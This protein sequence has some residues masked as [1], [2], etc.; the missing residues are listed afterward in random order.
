MKKLLLIVAL[1]FPLAALAQWTTHGFTIPSAHP[2]LWWNSARISAAQT[3]FASNP[4]TPGAC[5]TSGAATNCFN[6]A[7]QHVVAGDDCSSAVSWATTYVPL[8]TSPS[9][10]GSNDM[11]WYGETA[12]LV[13]DWCNDQ[14]TSGQKTTFITKWNTYVGNTD[15]QTWGGPTSVMSNYNWGNMRNDLEWGVASY[16][17]NG[18]GPGSTADNFIDSAITSRWGNITAA[19]SSELG[20]GIPVEG[21]EYGEAMTY[22]DIPFQTLELN[23]RDIFN[24]TGFFKQ[25]GYWLDY[26]T[27]PAPT[28]NNSL[29]ATNWQIIPFGDDEEYSRGGM[30]HVT[31]SYQSFQNLASN[32]WSSIGMGKNS[33]EWYNT[34]TGYDVLSPYNFTLAQDASPSASSFSSLPLDYYA[35]GAA[36]FYGKDSWSGSGTWFLWQLSCH[37]DL[38][39]GGAHVHQDYDTF[40]IWQ[41]GRWLSRESAGYADDDTYTGYNGTGT[42]SARDNIAHNGVLVNPAS[43]GCA[44]GSTCYGNGGASYVTTTLSC[45]TVR[46]LESQASYTYADTDT[47]NAEIGQHYNSQYGNPAVGYYGGPTGHMEREIIFVRP[48][49]TTVILDRLLSVSPDGGTHSAASMVKTFIAHCENNFT[50]VDGSH[51]TCTD[52]TQALYITNLEPATTTHEV[53]NEQTATSSKNGQYRLEVNDPGTTAQSYLLNVL[54][55]GASGGATVTASVVDSIPRD[56]TTG[57]F[58]VTLTPGVGSATTIVF[59]KG[60]TSSGGTINV[61]GAGTVNLAS[62]VEQISYTDS[63]PVWGAGPLPPT[64]VTGTAIVK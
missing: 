29:A 55:A 8:N 35:T 39:M 33:R 23:G 1:L 17:D 34:Y 13:Y 21:V 46:R 6:I 11:R 63:G 64:G 31:Q 25:Y 56:S 5:V 47:T 50:L 30:L 42:A 54:Q 45:P 12:I 41:N 48:L 7:W 2:R 19:A 43:V 61:A 3:W 59:N 4:F 32:Y 52:G 37:T 15:E 28:Y 49:E 27:L 58:I 9:N 60:E 62:T 20:G 18:S 40:Q 16:G 14:F 44:V 53:V 26:A 36:M 51:E 10:S 24:E 57:T 38:H 22:M